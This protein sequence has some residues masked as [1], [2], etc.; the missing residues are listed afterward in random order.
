MKVQEWL[1]AY[2]EY[3]YTSVDRINLR[4]LKILD[5]FPATFIKH[6]HLEHGSINY[7]DDDLEMWEV[8][9][10]RWARMLFL[11][12]KEER[13]LYPTLMVCFF[14]TALYFFFPTLHYI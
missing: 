7:D 1:W 10:K 6:S 12:I 9:A 5:D 13:H 8:E 3:Q 11:V 4:V 2:N 14:L